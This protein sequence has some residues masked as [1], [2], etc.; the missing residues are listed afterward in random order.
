MFTTYGTN[1]SCFSDFHIVLLRT[2]GS[3][4]LPVGYCAQ[5]GVLV[6]SDEQVRHGSA[7][8]K[9]TP[10]TSDGVMSDDC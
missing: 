10:E 2:P 5:F 8:T 3:E 6:L 4:T 7:F 1:R 9:S